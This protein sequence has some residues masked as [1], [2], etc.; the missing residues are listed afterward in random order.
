MAKFSLLGEGRVCPTISIFGVGLMLSSMKKG[1]GM[2]IAFRF[3]RIEEQC[4][5]VDVRFVAKVQ[6][7]T[8]NY[9]LKPKMPPLVV[10][11]N[12]GL[13]FGAGR[14]SSGGVVGAAGDAGIACGGGGGSVAKNSLLIGS[15]VSAS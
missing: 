12:A 7:K 11:E 8:R 10:G 6:E 2:S 1:R 3:G 9:F 14:F 5:V 15:P 13:H 4:L